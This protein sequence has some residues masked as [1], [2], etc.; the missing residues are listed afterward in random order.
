MNPVISIV[1]PTYNGAR[2]LEDAIQSVLNQTYPHWEL[3][4][5]DSYSTD[6]T[7]EIVAR[8]TAQDNRIRGTQNPKENGHLPGALNAGFDLA[9]GQYFAWFQDD[10]LFR[11]H[12][13]ETLLNY[14]L[15]HPDVD[16]VYSDYTRIG[17]Q[18]EEEAYIRVHEPN[19]LVRKS[20][21]DV[22]F[23]YKREV[24]EAL[25]GYDVSTFLVEDYDFWLRASI[26]FKLVA[27]HEDLHLYRFHE[28][29]LTSQ[30][31]QQVLVVREDVLT[32]LL[33][34]LT[35]MTPVD[36]A[37][38]YVHLGELAFM[39][40]KLGVAFSH[41]MTAFRASPRIVLQ[42]IVKQILPEPLRGRAIN[43]YR[44]MKRNNATT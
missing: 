28:G 43:V 9:Q 29:T 23:L 2:Y 34:Q 26:Q 20:A 3:I 41:W 15:A 14:L 35:W 11:P 27:L 32:R 22:S 37:R 31:L 21:V 33:P 42:H 4:I 25:G 6:A 5:V 19:L 7:P 10:N 16:L 44:R 17:A 8:Y 30:R 38:G 1:L 40:R 24:H 13:L 36:K 18:G 12:A 39:H